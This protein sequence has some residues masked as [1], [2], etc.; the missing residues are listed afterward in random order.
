MIASG[1]AAGMIWR[2]LAMVVRWNA[3]KG[4][5]TSPTLSMRGLRRFATKC[6]AMPLGYCTLR[7]LAYN[8]RPQRTA[9]CVAYQHLL[10]TPQVRHA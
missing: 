3:P 6:R 4:H 9:Q 5:S 7:V 2:R 1:G 8:P 10:G